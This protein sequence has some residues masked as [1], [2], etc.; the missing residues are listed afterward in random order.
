VIAS[1]VH[2]RQSS[3]ARQHLSRE[4]IL[5]NAS[6]PAASSINLGRVKETQEGATRRAVTE[7]KKGGLPGIL[8]GKVSDGFIAF[9]SPLDASGQQAE[10]SGR[11]RCRVRQRMCLA[12][13][14]SR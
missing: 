9:R 1:L 8:L 14:E 12:V 13:K 11:T 2:I 7:W 5:P 4:L 3:R 6:S 10:A